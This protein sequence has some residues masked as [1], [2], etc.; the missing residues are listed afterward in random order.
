MLSNLIQII[1]ILNKVQNE[2]QF[3]AAELMLWLSMGTSNNEASG[4][5][6]LQR[7]ESDEESIK[8]S[9]IHSSIGLEYNIVFALFL[10]LVNESDFEDLSFRD[11]DSG[12]YYFGYKD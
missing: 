5:E 10:D 1:E 2:K 12:V 8:N 3:S 11:E 6:Y 4:D 9:T 7:M